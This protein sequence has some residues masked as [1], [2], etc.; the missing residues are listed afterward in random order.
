MNLPEIVGVQDLSLVLRQQLQGLLDD[1][2]RPMTL[3]CNRHLGCE[4]LHHKGVDLRCSTA[5]DRYLLTALAIKHGFKRIGIYPGLIHLDVD[6][7]P[8]PALWVGQR[9]PRGG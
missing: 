1:L 2:G 8:Q 7:R 3:T 5:D 9:R 6:Q 4:A